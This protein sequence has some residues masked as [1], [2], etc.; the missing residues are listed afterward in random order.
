MRRAR[1]ARR[2]RGTTTRAGWRGAGSWR[3]RL[4]VIAAVTIWAFVACGGPPPGGGQPPDNGGSDAFFEGREAFGGPV[5]DDATIVSVDAFK[6]LAEEGGFVW[7]SLALRE[8]LAEEA[9]TRYAA[10]RAEVATLV[11]GNPDLAALLDEPDESADDLERLPSGDYLLG[12]DDGAGGS[13][14]VTTMAHESI[15]REAL[16]SAERFEAIGNLRALYRYAYDDTPA[17]V[18]AGL[19]TPESLADGSVA[20]LLDALEAL[21]AA[22]ALAETAMVEHYGRLQQAAF[23]V[24]PDVPGAISTA[25][26]AH[27]FRPP[28]F[29]TDPRLEEGSGIG[30]DRTFYGTF[31]PRD[32]PC[33]ISTEG[34]QQ[35]LWWPQKHYQTSIKQQ[36]K[37]GSCVAF[38]LASAIESNVAVRLNRWIN[39]SEQRLY[40]TIKNEWQPSHVRDGAVTANMA[41]ALSESGRAIPLEASWNY[42]PSWNRIPLAP[43]RDS[44]TSPYG[45]ACSDTAGQGRQV[46]TMVG[47][48]LFCAFVPQPG[49]SGGYGLSGATVVWNATQ[50][51]PIPTNTIWSMLNMGRPMVAALVVD[52]VFRNPVNGFVNPVPSSDTK[53]GHA[54]HLVGFIPAHVILANDDLPEAMRTR[55]LLSGGGFFVVKN[56]WGCSGDAG[57]WYLPVSWASTRFVSI[58]A[59]DRGSAPNYLA[60]NPTIEITSPA[61]GTAYPVSPLLQVTFTASVDDLS[62]GP[63]CCTV[64]WTS[65]VDGTLGTGATLTHD[66]GS[67]APGTRTIRATAV[68]AQGLAASDAISISLSTSAPSVSI[69]SPP[70]PAGTWRVELY[71]GV[72]YTFAGEEFAPLGGAQPCSAYE[73]TST[74]AGEGPWTGCSTTIAFET[75]GARTISLWV[76]NPSG[77]RGNDWLIADVVEPPIDGPPIVVIQRP[78]P[79]AIFERDARATLAS[80][81]VDPSG[82]PVP[83]S[84]LA[85]FISEGLTGE[86]TP[87][88]V[89]TG[90]RV[91]PGQ[92]SQSFEYFVPSDYVTPLCLPLTRPDIAPHV[93]LDATGSSGAIGSAVV[94]I[95]VQEASASCIN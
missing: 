52:E 24:A 84:A 55:A 75:L 71:R 40:Y 54:V 87:I 25:S 60:T 8:R 23:G 12:V 32:A 34:L 4:A 38:A 37:R 63:D 53:G 73:W 89:R 6:A 48:T 39:V 51:K 66:F 36:G 44:C 9:A 17:D 61:S 72:G 58:T 49:G 80:D 13:F 29:V 16:S 62:G 78:L 67:A 21:E 43:F 18:R 19:R 76:S 15:L 7:E 85:W 46:C 69:V 90:V 94:R 59:F 20:E 30:L 5:P 33:D 68:N 50:G 56:S 93:W 14:Q 79:D 82:E 91:R 81:V 47:S 2:L 10:D 27:D 77:E 74:R 26:L 92:P 45:E 65:S 83:P 86:R 28:G 42:N 31:D 95:Y 70:R 11:V 35:W 1:D 41:L 22:Q 57:Y 3:W 64:T 88:T